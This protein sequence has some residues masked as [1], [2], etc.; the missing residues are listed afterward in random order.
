MK[1]KSSETSVRIQTSILNGVE[2]KALIFLADRQPRWMTSNILTG[3]GTF[4][5]IV[6]SLGYILSQININYLWLSSLGFVIN[7]YGDSLDGTLARVRNKQR[8]IFGYY[9]DHTVDIIN[10]LLI[11]LGLGLS[12]L[13]CFDLSLFILIVYMM[14]T[15]NVSINAHLKKEFR[16]TYAKLGPTEFRVLAIIFNTV[17]IYCPAISDSVME[18]SMFGKDIV[19]GSL[20]IAG[21]FVLLVLIIMYIVTVLNDIKDYDKIDPMK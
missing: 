14:L 12:G 3:I 7:W 9:I 20:D 4:G 5:A 11:F 8:P 18:I 6:I 10:E 21:V 13:I 15:L 19:L 16:L 1:E 2:K 17:C